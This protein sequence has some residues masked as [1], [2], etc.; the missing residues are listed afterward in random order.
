MQLFRILLVFFS[1]VCATNATAQDTPA[2]L[3]LQL[4]A[5][6]TLGE[7]C[8]LTFVLKNATPEDIDKLVAETV[9]FSSDGGVVLLTLFDFAALPSGRP[10]VRQF[11]IPDNSCD[12]IGQ[13]LIN[14]VDSCTVGGVA[15]SI[16]EEN[17]SVSSRVAIELEG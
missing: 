13:V 5:V 6:D 17:L 10:R 4:N 7:N 12:R 1:L 8:R 16:C 14:G 9:L 11:Q 2:E 3:S 15:S